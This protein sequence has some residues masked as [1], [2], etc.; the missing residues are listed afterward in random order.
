MVMQD[1]AHVHEEIRHT[2]ALTGRERLKFMDRPILVR[3]TAGDDVV[4]QLQ[5]LIE[6]PKR[7][8]TGNLLIVGESNNGK[9]TLIARFHGEEH[10]KV[11]IDDAG[12]EKRVA[13]PIIVV[14]APPVADEKSLYLMILDRFHAPFRAIAPVSHLRLQTIHL[15][16]DCGTR[17][18]IIDEFHSLLTGTTRKQQEVMNTIKLLCNELQI[19]IVAVGTGVAVNVLHTDPQHASR[20]RVVSLPKWRPNKDFQD[21][22]VDLEKTLPLMHP[23]DLGSGARAKLLHT[24]CEGNLG[25]LRE[26]LVACAR[27]AIEEGAERITPE[28][29]E[30]MTPW[31]RPTSGIGDHRR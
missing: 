8:R 22:V 15:L 2:L 27:K 30:R 6:M 9:T 25:N 17:M 16:R 23:S 28:L 7:P 12:N 18:L 14:D 5:R 3:Y 13:K 29:I 10:H 24:L 19:P 4:A 21:L 26:G 1:G 11:V 31:F 20:F